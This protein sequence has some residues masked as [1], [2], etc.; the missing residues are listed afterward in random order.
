MT[1]QKQRNRDADY[2]A[3]AEFRYEIRRYLNFSEGAARAAGIEPHQHQALLAIK[4]V[5]RGQDPTIGYLAER[6]LIRHHSTVELTDR[7][8]KRR[9]IRRSRGRLD[10]REVLLQLTPRGEDLLGNLSLAHRAE[11][12]LAGPK[13][14]E[15]LGA[16]VAHRNS[17]RRGRGQHVEK[18][19]EPRSAK[20]NRQTK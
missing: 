13:L 20:R 10:R 16:L 9:L 19:G 12:R 6:L 8:E 11:L 17:P 2:R 14:L 18:P 5:L 7:L 15:A 4:G 1:T 3:L